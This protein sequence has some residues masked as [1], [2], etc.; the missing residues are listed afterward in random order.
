MIL[1][2]EVAEYQLR[3]FV[4]DL[5]LRTAMVMGLYAVA[6]SLALEKLN[7]WFKGVLLLLRKTSRQQAGTAGI[8]VFFACA[9]AATFY[10][11]LQLELH[12]PAGLLPNSWR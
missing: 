7:P 2:E 11:Y 10:G 5:Y 9:Y 6:F 3:K 1:A 8:W 4:D 12:G